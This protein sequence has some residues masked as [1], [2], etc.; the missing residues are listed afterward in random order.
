MKSDYPVP[1]PHSYWVIPGLLLAGEFPGA[2]D[3]SEARHKL[4]SL[5]EAGIRTIFNLMEPDETDHTGNQFNSYDKLFT[6]IAVERGSRVS[7]NRYP[8]KDLNIPDTELMGKILD[9]IDDAI[10]QRKPAY[11]HCWD[12]IGRTGA[13][14]GCFLIRHG[15]ANRKNVLEVIAR[16][17]KNDQKAYRTSPETA[18]Q[19]EFVKT[20]AKN[21]SGAPT[22][23][24]RY[25]GCMIG[26]AVGDALGAPVEFMPLSQI[27]Q[28]YGNDGIKGYD[29]AYGRIG[30]ITDDT[31]MA[32][33][34]AE[35][36]LRAW[37][38][39]N[40]KGICHPP[41]VVHHAYLR[42]LRTQESRFLDQPEPN[43]EGF[44]EY[45]P[46][47]YSWRAPGNSCLSA[48]HASEMGTM[49][50]P[51]NNSKGCGGVMRA[52]PVG[53][54]AENPEE[55]FKL[56]C[57]VAAITHGHPTGYLAS[58][59][60]AAMIKLIIQGKE[61]PAAI[62]YALRLL[63]QHRDHQE[64]TDAITQAVDLAGKGNPKPEI[65]KQMG[66]GWIAEEA[67]AISVCCALCAGGDYRKGVLL[68]VNHSGDSDSTGAI[69]GNIL[70]CMLGN[71]S[72]PEKWIE[73]LELKDIIRQLGIDLFIQF[74]NDRQW[75]NKYPGW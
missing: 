45:V 56:G 54:M 13:V 34:T 43:L 22:K 61:L 66:E 73:Q 68:A 11:V 57:E 65:I 21:E 31:Q 35:G 7:C 69:T 5:F 62:D 52:A 33:F 37:T 58:G 64:T 42:W 36:L 63:E 30:A 8:I 25:L 15:L 75:W 28:T 71:S 10:E 47:L 1:F 19:V 46:E 17:R 53:L 39:G 74:R 67:L 70:G 2:K 27:H 14:V 40:T 55:S 49:D 4:E 59:A 60:L 44:L 20:W 9:A 72:I 6:D 32:M 16:L 48:L 3:P 24:N 12:G 29:R 18:S 26:G 41:S 50:R 23:L 51:V 38:R